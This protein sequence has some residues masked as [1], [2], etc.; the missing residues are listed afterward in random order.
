[1]TKDHHYQAIVCIRKKSVIDPPSPPL[2]ISAL[3]F[4]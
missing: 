2:V 1:M 3:A 4:F